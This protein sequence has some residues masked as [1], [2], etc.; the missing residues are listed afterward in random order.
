MTLYSGR[1]EEELA[2]A[3][4]QVLE[5]LKIPAQNEFEDLDLS[6]LQFRPH[7]GPQKI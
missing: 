4:E 3:L 6:P 2:S 1:S 5:E 7:I